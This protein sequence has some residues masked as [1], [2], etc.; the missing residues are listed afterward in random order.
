MTTPAT[1][2]RSTSFLVPLLVGVGAI[3]LAVVLSPVWLLIA[4]VAALL[5]ISRAIR[6]VA[7]GVLN[8]TSG[9]TLIALN[10][11]LIVASW[12]VLFA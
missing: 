10:F 7:A 6:A 12:W 9:V 4:V 5:N 1:T 11:I 3:V 8:P 2:A